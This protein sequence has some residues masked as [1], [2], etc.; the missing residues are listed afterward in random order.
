MSA[1]EKLKAK[2]KAW[3]FKKNMEKFDALNDKLLS[4]YLQGWMCLMKENIYVYQI[5]N[6]CTEKHCCRGLC[7]EMND[8]LVDEKKRKQTSP[9]K[10][11]N[12]LIK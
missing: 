6:K 12:N 10:W 5:C 2:Y 7:K 9:L 8:Y 4:K 3:K 11:T 1:I